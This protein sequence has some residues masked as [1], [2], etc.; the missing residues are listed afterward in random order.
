MLDRSGSMSGNQWNS[1]MNAVKDF[2]NSL[3]TN[4]NI[5]DHVKV[6]I[7]GYCSSS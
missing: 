7:I 3:E 5:K 1:L 2:I 6:S 4:I